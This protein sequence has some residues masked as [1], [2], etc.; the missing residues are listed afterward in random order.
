LETYLTSNRG[1]NG[2]VCAYDL[3]Y[4]FAMMFFTMA[5]LLNAIRWVVLI[6]DLQKMTAITNKYTLRVKLGM[7]AILATLV[8]VSVFRMIAEC[9]E[10][11]GGELDERLQLP[12][13]FATVTINLVNLIALIL[14]VMAAKMNQKYTKEQC[15]SNQLED[16]DILQM[17][18]NARQILTFFIIIIGIIIARIILTIVYEILTVMNFKMFQ[19]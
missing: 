9:Q 11:P 12:V 13:L 15:T 3:A 6:N 4:V 7:G 10:H 14:I 8:T 5:I 16:K 19:R 17:Q 18:K 1:K 2:L